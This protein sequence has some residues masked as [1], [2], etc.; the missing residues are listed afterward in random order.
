MLGRQMARFRMSIYADDTA[1]FIK[2]T[3]MDVRNLDR[4]LHLFGEVTGLRTDML[5]TSVM[6]STSTAIWQPTR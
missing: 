4:L 3:V 6:T 2:P 1:I 5:K